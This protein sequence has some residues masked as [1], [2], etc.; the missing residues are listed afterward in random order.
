MVFLIQEDPPLDRFPTNGALGH[1]V[2]AHLAGAVAAQ[3][4]HVLQP[5]ET[6]GAHRLKE[7]KG[8][9]SKFRGILRT[10]REILCRL[11]YE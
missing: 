4:D 1:P 3:E 9:L 2:A 6:H 7:F 5:V 10:F 8:I 11:L